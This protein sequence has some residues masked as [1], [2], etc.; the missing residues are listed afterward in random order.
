MLVN[1]HFHNSVQV[2]INIHTRAKVLNKKTIN[3]QRLSQ[4]LDLAKTGTPRLKDT[5]RPLNSQYSN[6]NKLH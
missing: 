3:S 4:N 6:F 1:L 2:R 5:E